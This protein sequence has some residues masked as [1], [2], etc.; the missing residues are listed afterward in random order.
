MM[1]VRRYLG[2]S[3]RV[4]AF[5]FVA[6]VIWLLF[7]MA[8]LRLSINDVNSHILKERVIRERELLKK[9]SR[10]AQLTV[11]GFKHPLQRVNVAV[12]SAGKGLD[13]GVRLAKVYRQREKE[14]EQKAGAKER[15]ALEPQEHNL[16]KM[17]PPKYLL[18]EQ[19]QEI[20]LQSIPPKTDDIEKKG[21]KG[22]ESLEIDESKKQKLPA[23]L[24]G[25]RIIQEVKELSL[26]L[27]KKE[28][29]K[30][31]V[32]VQN[33]PEISDPKEPER[34]KDEPRRGANGRP[35]ETRPAQTAPQPPNKDTHVNQANMKTEGKR[36][37]QSDLTSAKERVKP[38]AGPEPGS[39][40]NGTAVGRAGV[41]RVQHL[42]ATLVPRDAR[43]VGQFGQAVLVSSR[44]DANVRRRW[45]EGFFNVY[46]SD[47]IPVDRAIPDTRPET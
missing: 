31:E 44:D 6:S 27:S 20:V 23:V 12:P 33:T 4:L 25:T 30:V 26:T 46:L 22:G 13:S 7:D 1:K 43:A 34:A 2:G 38:P 37:V 21:I 9:Q 18:T 29:A 10:S 14:P 19:K 8:A 15:K 16:T 32:V 24:N 5:V 42:D 17:S 36:P 41:H 47:Q 35:L 39:Q 40:P 11:G 45:D 28:S 3:G